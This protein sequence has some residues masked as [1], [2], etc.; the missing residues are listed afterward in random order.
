VGDAL[1]VI[2][3]APPILAYAST[4]LRDSR[5]G[6]RPLEAALC[7]IASAIAGYFLLASTLPIQY[8]VFPFVVWAALRLLQLG[9]TA[10]I[11]MLCVISIW[12]TANGLGPHPEFS[13]TLRLV[14]LDLFNGTLAISGLLLAAVSEERLRATRALLRAADGLEHEVS[15]RTE[16]LRRQTREVETARD[17]A[18]AASRAKGEYLSRMS[19][20]L[21]TP[22]SVIIG[23]SD[24]LSEGSLPAEEREHLDAIMRSAEHL[25]ALVNDVLDIARIE[26]G[27]ETLE[28]ES[29]DIAALCT[30]ATTMMASVAHMGGVALSCDVSGVQRAVRG[31]RRRLLQV[32]LNL[33]SNGVK[34][35]GASVDVSVRLAGDRTARILVSDAGPGLSDGEQQLLFQP[36]ERLGAQQGGNDGTGLGLALSKTLMEGMGGTIGVSS[37]PRGA[38]FWVS[39][40]LDEEAPD[41]DA[42]GYGGDG[43]MR[44]LGAGRVRAHLSVLHIEDNPLMVEFV[45]RLCARRANVHVT[46]TMHG[47]MGLEL[48][49]AALPDLIILDVHLPDID[50]EE[51]LRRLKEDPVTR[52]IPVVILSADATPSTLKKLTALGALQYVTKPIRARQFLDVLDEATARRGAD[53]SPSGRP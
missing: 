10:V 15:V 42:N 46:N 4:P 22:L 38:T 32:L 40:P 43:G 35:G 2:L 12:T 16:E 9:A 34:Y 18:Q 19:H 39:L 31:D 52:D 36:F 17:A 24:L 29:I 20:E 47:R 41:R 13:A 23:Y 26:A 25:L 14:G 30:E 44:A 53:A 45:E 1:G 33:I 21:R 49:K 7:L 3:F 27:Q 28:L 11:L 6:S 5:F 50:G 51:V 8:L 48:A 37:A